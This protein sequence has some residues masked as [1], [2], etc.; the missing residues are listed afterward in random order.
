DRRRR[1]RSRQ[2]LLRSGR[3]L[4]HDPKPGRRP[5]RRAA[6]V[7]RQRRHRH[8]LRAALPLYDHGTPMMHWIFYILLAA[9]PASEPVSQPASSP[10]D[11]ADAAEVA[12]AEGLLAEVDKA[13]PRARAA[14]KQASDL[15]PDNVDF[16]FDLARVSFERRLETLAADAA[17]FLALPPK[18]SA[19][20]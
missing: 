5:R 10:A 2:R 17:R 9:E 19:H 18:T 7:R 3:R 1:K 6:L 16:A 13:Y 12:H 11:L 15:A 4:R 20:Y 8:R 14:L